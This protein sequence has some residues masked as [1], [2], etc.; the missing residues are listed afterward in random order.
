VTSGGEERF[1]AA[2]AKWRETAPPPDPRIVAFLNALDDA[3]C[4]VPARPAPQLVT[5][6]APIAPSTDPALFCE[7]CG[8]AL[9]I[10]GCDK[11]M[12]SLCL[13][14]QSNCFPPCQNARRR[15]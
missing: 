5:P 6:K 3:S 11:V 2:L 1:Q 9:R 15:F 13:H 14:P 10:C 4:D 8:V 12:C 7:H